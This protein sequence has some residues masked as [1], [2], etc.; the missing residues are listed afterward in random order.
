MEQMM[1]SEL[2]IGLNQEFDAMHENDDINNPFD[3]KKEEQHV[4]LNIMQEKEM[5]LEFE[6][7]DEKSVQTILTTLNEND[8]NHNFSPQSSVTT[9]TSNCSIDR[10]CPLPDDMSLLN[11][12]YNQFSDDNEQSTDEEETVLNVKDTNTNT[13]YNHYQKSSDSTIHKKCSLPESN[14]LNN[15]FNQSSVD[16]GQNN[17][18][19]VNYNQHQ[20]LVYN[21]EVESRFKYIRRML[22]KYPLAVNSGDV[23]LIRSVV[24]EIFTPNCRFQFVHMNQEETGR[25]KL[26]FYLEKRFKSVPDAIISWSPFVLHNS[27]VLFAKQ[28]CSGTQLPNVTTSQTTD[29][30]S[31]TT[32]SESFPYFD[33]RTND[34]VYDRERQKAT[35]L[36]EK[37]KLVA[38]QSQCLIY[39]V[40]NREL[41]YVERFVIVRRNIKVS[42]YKEANGLKSN[43]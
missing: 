15:Q 36:L 24:S 34:P 32:A 38:F 7:S 3:A 5:L 8:T 23:Q 30:S 18:L 28:R 13:N 41:T 27:H 43:Y 17:V 29:S 19:K 2:G 11:Y 26:I 42:E 35:Q 16:D 22:A 10:K 40:L 6:L 31:A 1:F 9:F 39:F 25:D 14:L 4:Q 20:N 12:Q 33:N 21:P 37:Q